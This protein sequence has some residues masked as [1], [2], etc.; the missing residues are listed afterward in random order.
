MAR[1]VRISKE[2]L[3]AN[4]YAVWN[5]FV[6][7]LAF[8][9]HDQMTSVQLPAFLAFWYEQEVQNGGHYQYFQNRGTDEVDFLIVALRQ[10]SADSLAQVAA[11]A[12]ERLVSHPPERVRT[13]EEFVDGALEGT[14]DEI[15]A[16]FHKCSPTIVE[17]L[18]AYLRAHE[19][20]FIERVP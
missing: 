4:P 18:E 1:P 10:L 16:A 9:K 5:Q 11:Q 13:P 6:H 15:D 8:G 20:D 17:A 19:S 3:A 2:Q 14:F 7:L 12:K